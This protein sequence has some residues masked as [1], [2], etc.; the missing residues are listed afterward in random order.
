MHC[1]YCVYPDTQVVNSRLTKKDT[2][3]WRRRRCLNCKA[4]FTTHEMVDLSHLM[5][6][7]KTGKIQKF[8]KM[9][10]YSGIYGA[11]IGSKTPNREYLVDKITREVEIE[12][13]ALKRKIINSTEIADIVL[14]KL[15]QLHTAT[16]LRFLAYCKDITNE[17]QMKKEF[18]KYTK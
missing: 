11:T 17:A 15:K 3:V 12:I 9:K 1:P 4:V 8:N 16:F 10:L 13:L 5:V 6:L 18:T 7:K 14:F 2:Q